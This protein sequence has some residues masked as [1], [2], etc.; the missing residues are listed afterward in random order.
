MYLT[1]QDLNNKIKEHAKRRQWKKALTLIGIRVH[2]KWK[3]YPIY[4]S[5]ELI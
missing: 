4:V 3:S 2:N 5:L 1:E